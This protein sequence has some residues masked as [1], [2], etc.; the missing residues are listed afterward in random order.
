MRVTPVR[1]MTA[2]FILKKTSFEL[3]EELRE[4]FASRFYHTQTAERARAHTTSQTNRAIQ[5]ILFI[6]SFTIFYFTHIFV[7]TENAQVQREH[8]KGEELAQDFPAT[9]KLGNE[10]ALAPTEAASE[11]DFPSFLNRFIEDVFNSVDVKPESVLRWMPK[12]TPKLDEDGNVIATEPRTPKSPGSPHITLASGDG[13][14]LRNCFFSHTH[15]FLL[16]VFQ[17]LINFDIFSCLI[18]SEII[19]PI[20]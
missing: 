17:I 1:S 4:D 8:K 6:S 2:K 15:T 9:T 5:R 12:V 19:C 11:Q 14:R 18:E 3:E 7:K 10:I 13:K 16:D 20:S